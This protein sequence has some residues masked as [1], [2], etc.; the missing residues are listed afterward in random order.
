VQE[1]L[2]EYIQH[3]FDLVKELRVQAN[4]DPSLAQPKAQQN[5]RA[6]LVDDWESVRV[7]L[8]LLSTTNVLLQKLSTFE[9]V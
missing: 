5:S 1:A 6:A 3:L 8:S 7:A 2:L 4:V 9:K